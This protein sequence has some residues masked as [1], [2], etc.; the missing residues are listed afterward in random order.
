M[1]RD[2]RLLYVLWLVVANLGT[3]TSTTTTIA[4]T[5]KTT[6]N[7]TTISPSS[8]TTTTTT[9]TVR[10]A[11][12]TINATATQTTLTT[13]TKPPGPCDSNPCGRGSTCEIR[14]NQTHVCLCLPG[15]IYNKDRNS[16]ET[17]KVFPGQLILPLQYNDKMSDKTS[18]E[19]AEASKILPNEL[20]NIFGE[21][22]TYTGSIVLELRPTASRAAGGVSASIEI[23]FSEKSDITTEQV[24]ES[25]VKATN[26]DGC[27]LAGG[28]FDETQLCSKDPCDVQTT[29]CKSKNGLY[30]CTCKESYVRTDFSVRMCIACPSGQKAEGS[31][32]CV[33]C[34]FGYS[35][36]NCNE[37]WQLVL[38]IVGSVLGGLLL[39]TLI[40]LP[41]VATINSK[42][43]SKN[44]KHA[45][46][47]NSYKASSPAKAPLVNSSFAANKLHSAN[48]SS[49]TSA[50]MPTI[51]RATT[52]SHS[53]T[54]LEMTPSNSQQNLI[55]ADRNSRL[56]DNH[57]EIYPYSQSRPHPG[58]YGGYGQTRPQNNPYA[59]NPPQ[60]N[61]YAQSQGRTNPYYT[62]NEGR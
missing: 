50:G 22:D 37:S 21:S 1:A 48:G 17:A 39:I 62:H 23:T 24:Q 52:T 61:P 7:A 35:G 51:P 28:S 6:T 13:T 36:L 58:G 11:P 2:F 60:I 45:D 5:T 32:K 4:P 3:G 16:C 25:M 15:E 42:K 53:N 19:F 47:G 55:S 10:P 41:V 31:V 14:A 40:L 43:S 20:S 26:C 57:D 59:R 30:N 56:Y 38:V 34:P 9:T 29:E 8:T 54:N 18:P 12:T 27:L 44:D 33:S 46:N 49:F